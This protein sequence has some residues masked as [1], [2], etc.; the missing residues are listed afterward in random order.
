[1]S[2]TSAVRRIA[3]LREMGLTPVWV[4]RDTPPIEAPL[5]ETQPSDAQTILQR[6]QQTTSRTTSTQA[7]RSSP[8]V[9]SNDAAADAEIDKRRV[10]IV[11]MDWSALNAAVARSEEHN[12]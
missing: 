4:T 10:Q 12:V 11:Q 1:M 8:V 5:G 3:M 6:T 2:T 7:A 9:S